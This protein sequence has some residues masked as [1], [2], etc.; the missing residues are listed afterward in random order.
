RA[1]LAQ[2][3]RVGVDR[4]VCLGDVATLGPHPERVLATLE[5]R[6]C[7][8]ILGNH[9]EFLLD[10]ELI[11]RYTELPIVLDAVTWCRDR[12]SGPQLDFVRT[13]LPQLEI[14]LDDRG[15]S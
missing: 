3:D 2:I 11:R 15:A 8:V 6:G 14:P 7:P 5:E 12:L 10:A 13:F 9:D 1:V 4:L